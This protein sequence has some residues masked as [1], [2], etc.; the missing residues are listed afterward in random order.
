[1]AI[2]TSFADVESKSFD[3]LPVG[4]YPAKVT[5]LMY[6]EENP[7]EAKGPYVAWTF[8]VTEGEYMGRK[9][10]LN[11]S[12]QVADE[13]TGKKDARWATMRIL[14][15]LGFSEEE[16]K[17]KEWDF[18]DPEV[19]DELIGRDCVISIGHQKFEGETKQRVRR[20]LPTT[21]TSAAS[22]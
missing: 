8:E 4:R 6:N 11:S 22:F 3:P 15:A 5:E 1:M 14:T 17:S 2:P 21:S 7:S 10:F 9:A 16:V 18:E 13:A 19:V 20:V 12:L